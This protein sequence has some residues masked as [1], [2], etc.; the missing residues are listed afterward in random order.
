LKEKFMQ[1]RPLHSSA[2]SAAGG[3]T[4]ATSVSADD[5]LKQLQQQR[6]SH[7]EQLKNEGNTLMQ[8]KSY[9]AAIAA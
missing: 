5:A 2:A 9:E 1:A 4:P 6:M 8:A 7:G 3:A